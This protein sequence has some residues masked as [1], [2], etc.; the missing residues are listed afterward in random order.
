VTSC[1][2]WPPRRLTR[3]L[4]GSGILFELD[5]VLAGLHAKRGVTDNASRR[6][7]L[8]DQLKQAFPGSE[9]QAP[10]TGSTATG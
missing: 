6:Q 7:H 4:W 8:F 2:S 1:C 9:V 10:K 5:Y 3:P